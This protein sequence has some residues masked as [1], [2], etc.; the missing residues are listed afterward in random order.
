MRETPARIAFVLSLLTGRAREWGT[1]AWE[2]RNSLLWP[3]R[4]LQ[5]GDDQDLRSFCFR[6]R[7]FA[8]THKRSSRAEGQSL[9]LP[10]S[11][12]TLATTCE[13]NEPAAGRS[14]FG[15]THMDLRR[16][17][18]RVD[19]RLN[20]ITAHRTGYSPGQVLRATRRVR[21]SVSRPLEA[22]TPAVVSSP[23]CSDPEPMQL[24]GVRISAEERER[25]IRSRLCLYCG[26][27]GHFGCFMSVKSQSSP[28]DGGVLASATVI[29][30]LPRSRTTISAVLRW[31]GITVNGSRAHRFR[32]PRAVSLMRDGRWNKG[33]PCWTSTTLPPSLRLMAGHFLPF[34][35]SLSG[36]PY[37]LRKS[38]RDYIFFVFQ[39][40]YTPIVLGHPWLTQHNPQIDWVKGS[41][42]SWNL[43]GH[44]NCLVS[45]CSCCFFCVCV[46]GGAW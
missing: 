29:S 38:Q 33:S 28:V 12:R 39:S 27:N 43:S 7:G 41:I 4:A 9:I 40:P 32:G 17:S 22:L 46:S 45:C 35:A 44:V 11:F 8:P 10:L 15:G 34:V 36:E 19:A 2:A 3:L 24:G 1:S 37:R 42:H 21:G 25:R 30:S 14:F 26:A 16:R 23:L 20:W 6:S 5:G 31:A 13:W 18:M